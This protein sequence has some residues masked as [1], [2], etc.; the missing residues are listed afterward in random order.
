M[1][2]AEP[3]RAAVQNMLHH[4]TGDLKRSQAIEG[5]IHC[6]AAGEGQAYATITERILHAAQTRPQIARDL[7]PAALA[8]ASSD[9]LARGTKAEEVRRRQRVERD[10]VLNL[11][12]AHVEEMR[13]EVS[14]GS[15]IV[16][17]GKCKSD[18]VQWE[19]KQTRGADEPMTLFCK[20]MACGK[21]WRM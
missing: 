3:A 4:I 5:A 14:T 12:E 17:C 21:Q 11:I 8:C 16:V 18:N 2:V 20:C 15:S 6:A 7:S 1:R 19:Q 9:V 13:T 10:T